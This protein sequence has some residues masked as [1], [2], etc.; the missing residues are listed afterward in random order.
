VGH[1]QAVVGVVACG[2]DGGSGEFEVFGPVLV[3]AAA[4]VV[5]EGECG[6]CHCGCC[7]WWEVSLDG[8]GTS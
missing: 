4:V 2:C 7:G 6:G 3:V 1:A 8:E 5:L